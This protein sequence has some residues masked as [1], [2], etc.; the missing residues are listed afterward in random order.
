MN[1]KK[2]LVSQKESRFIDDTRMSIERPF[3]GDWNLHVRDVQ[4][5]DRGVYT[6][7]VNSFPV[8]V[9]HINLTVQGK[10]CSG[11]KRFYFRMKN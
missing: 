7:T 8:V 11:I 2:I 3:L 6:C 1:P 5:K 9:R 10:T 4:Y